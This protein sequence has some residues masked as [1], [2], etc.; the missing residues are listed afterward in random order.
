MATFKIDLK[1]AYEAQNQLWRAYIWDPKNSS[2]KAPCTISIK[3]GEPIEVE[4]WKALKVFD[5][6]FE[7]LNFHEPLDYLE[8]ETEEGKSF[9]IHNLV[10]EGYKSGPIIPL[11]KIIGEY[12]ISGASIKPKNKVVKGLFF[13]LQYL[14]EWLN[15]NPISIKPSDNTNEKNYTINVQIPKQLILVNT[16]TY[17]VSVGHR[18]SFPFQDVNRLK[19]YP[20][21]YIS[22]LYQNKTTLF[23]SI[24][25]RDAIYLLVKNLIGVDTR[26][27]ESKL[28]LGDD[29]VHD[30]Y[31]F[32][33]KMTW[34]HN[35]FSKRN[36]LLEVNA[37]LPHLK[38]MIPRWIEIYSE[39]QEAIKEYYRISSSRDFVNKREL[40]I[41]ATQGI[42][43]Y[44]KI[45]S[46][47]IEIETHFPDGKKK[48]EFWCSR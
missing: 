48:G 43:M 29:L 22:I 26:I 5:Y 27:T 37:I 10:L 7:S 32:D 21:P 18:F 19:V 44:F 42:E 16:E 36:I 31:F 11:V 14:D 3:N 6:F 30:L 15:I 47:K 2:E 39:N 20:I 9:S 34:K 17:K 40:F 41:N 35:S 45:F 12:L 46:P 4:C 28:N 38:I 23:E 1:S 25:I 24:R 13:R 33:N 8:G